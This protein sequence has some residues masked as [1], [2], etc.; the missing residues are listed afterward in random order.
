MLKEEE[1]KEEEFLAVPRGFSR[2]QVA[3][4]CLSLTAA[5]LPSIVLSLLSSPSSYLLLLPRLL[6]FYYG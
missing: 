1:E 3:P 4:R 6:P 5:L 2:E